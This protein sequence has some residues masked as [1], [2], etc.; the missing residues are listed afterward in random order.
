[1]V[2]VVTLLLREVLSCLCAVTAVVGMAL[3]NAWATVDDIRRPYVP[4]T[5]CC[6]LNVHTC[7]AGRLAEKRCLLLASSP[8]STQKLDTHD[9]ADSYVTTGTVIVSVLRYRRFSGWALVTINIFQDFMLLMSP[10]NWLIINRLIILVFSCITSRILQPVCQN[11]RSL[12]NSAVWVA[13]FGFNERH[14]AFRVWFTDVGVCVC[15][16][17]FFLLVVIDTVDNFATVCSRVVTY[18]LHIALV[19]SLCE[20]N[21]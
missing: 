19:A 21:A 12:L 2:I 10:I 9:C 17:T 5:M 20:C 3:L 16:W 1:M 8:L 11:C 6:E 4:F 14:S 15:E 18:E 13:H 7:Q